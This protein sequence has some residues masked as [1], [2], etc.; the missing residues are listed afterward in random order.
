MIGSL[1]A[2]RVLV[3]NSILIV[4]LKVSAASVSPVL[5]CHNYP[6][7]RIWPPF[8]VAR[9]WR[10]SRGKRGKRKVVRGWKLDAHS[11]LSSGRI[12]GD[13]PA[14]PPATPSAK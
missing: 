9:D 11:E 5:C 12:D 8:L 14:D 2:E 3:R 7:F 1:I 10:K 13:W 4:R 6:L